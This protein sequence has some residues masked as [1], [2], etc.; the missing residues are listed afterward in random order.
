M[1]KYPLS[2]EQRELA[3]KYLEEYQTLL[4]L[5][6]WRITLS[7]KPAQKGTMAD[8]RISHEDHLAT[9]SLGADWGQPPTDEIIRQTLIHELLHVFLRP[10]MDACT[11]RDERAIEAAEHSAIV[12]LERLL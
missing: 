3:F 1:K 7:D 9:V 2:I 10:L 4:N 5:R 11:A 12:V 6:D 8:V